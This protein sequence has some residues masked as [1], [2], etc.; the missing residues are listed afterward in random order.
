VVEDKPHAGQCLTSAGLGAWCWLWERSA[1]CLLWQRRA[2]LHALEALKVCWMC[3]IAEAARHAIGWVGAVEHELTGR[4][5]SVTRRWPVCLVQH[6]RCGR[7]CAGAIAHERSPLAHRACVAAHCRLC[8]LKDARLAMR[9]LD[10]CD[11]DCRAWVR[12]R[13]HRWWHCWQGFLADI[14]NLFE[15]GV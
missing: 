5:V 2:V 8:G 12:S 6:A 9:V 14:R 7:G 15:R 3:W 4:R 1:W 10:G 11:A 13:S